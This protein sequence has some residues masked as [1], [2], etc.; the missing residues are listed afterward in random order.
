M[1]PE[2]FGAQLDERTTVF[3]LGRIIW[4]FATRLTEQRAMFCGPMAR[5]RRSN[6]HVSHYRP[7]DLP[8]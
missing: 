5:L 4:H 3:T 2:E 1:A 8:A 7:T 6:E